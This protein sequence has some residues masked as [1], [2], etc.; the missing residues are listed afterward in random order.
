MLFVNVVG[1]GDSGSPGTRSFDEF[2]KQLDADKNGTIEVS[3][4]ENLSVRRLLEAVD[5]D[6]N[7]SVNQQEYEANIRKDTAAGA[8]WA[9]RLGGRGDVSDSHVAWRHRRSLPDVPSPLLY[10]DVVYLLRDG[11]IMT[12]LDPATGKIHKRGRMR[13]AIDSYYSSPV[14][15]SQSHF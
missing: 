6:G 7:G 13:G 2:V 5:Q 15:G 1:A 14:A 3:E 12:S 9:I 11:G 4:S 10:R 8:L